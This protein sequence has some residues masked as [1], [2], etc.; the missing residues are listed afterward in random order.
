MKSHCHAI[1][2]LRTDENDC[3]KHRK[4]TRAATIEIN[5]YIYIF[6]VNTMGH[7]KYCTLLCHTCSEKIG[8]IP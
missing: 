6:V 3:R 2:T 4:R 1:E 8:K 5:K 7:V